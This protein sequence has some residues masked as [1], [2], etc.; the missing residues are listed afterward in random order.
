MLSNHDDDVCY[1]NISATV[2]STPGVVRRER[3]VAT[4]H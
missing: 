4:L 2:I 3:L 1:N